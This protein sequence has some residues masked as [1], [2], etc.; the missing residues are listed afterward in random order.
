M[1]LDCLLDIRVVGV[2]LDDGW[3]L[4]CC[5]KRRLIK[6]QH[7]T[8]AQDKRMVWGGGGRERKQNSHQYLLLPHS[9]HRSN[10]NEEVCVALS[11]TALYHLRWHCAGCSETDQ[12]IKHAARSCTCKVNII[13]GPQSK[14]CFPPARCVNSSAVDCGQNKRTAVLSARGINIDMLQWPVCVN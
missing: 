7:R 1:A 11:V 8:D 10:L 12:R 3:F 9:R 4:L 5:Q 6:E 13:T 14:N 2:N